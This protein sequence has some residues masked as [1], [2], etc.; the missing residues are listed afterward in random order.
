MDKNKLKNIKAV[1]FDADGVLFT[2]SVFM[3]QEGEA[4]KERSHID[5]HGI[6]LLRQNGI[7]VC[8]IT[9]EKS[10]FLQKVADKWNNGK[11]E[12]VDIFMDKEGKDKVKTASLWL[13]EKNIS[14]Q[15]CAAMG[16]DLTDYHLL[17][18]SVFA[19]APAQA[20][21]EI[22]KIADFI[23]PRTGGNGAIRDFCNLI[24][25]AKGI[26]PIN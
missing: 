4:M 20:E 14:W 24:L 25:E 21:Q 15:N 6:S 2:G 22:K 3:N 13:K 16:D 5:G 18:E 26:N 8:F 17:K 19:V 11:L 10:A 9:A 12:K 7:K 23:T 1:V